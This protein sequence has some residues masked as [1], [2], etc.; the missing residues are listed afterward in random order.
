MVTTCSGAPVNL[1]LRSSCWVVMPTGQVF[2]W[3]CL[4]IL[5]PSASSGRCQIRTLGAEQGGDQ[6]VPAGAQTAVGLEG[7]PGAETVGHQILV[8]LGQ[9]DLPRRPGVL[10]RD[11]RR[12]PGAAPGARDEDGVGLRLGHP[13][14]HRPY[15]GLGH[16]LHRHPGHRVE[17]LEVVDELG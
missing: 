11:Q 3:H 6:H 13:D 7:N 10:D 1:A 8:R 12:R 15:T 17:G 5:Q 9:P 4:T 14:G 2:R 16:Q